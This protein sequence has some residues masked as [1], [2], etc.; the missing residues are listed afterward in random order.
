MAA[1]QGMRVSPANHS[2]ARL[3]RKCDY[4]TDTKTERQTPDKMIPMCRYASQT[5]QQN[6]TVQNSLHKICLK[7]DLQSPMNNLPV[8]HCNPHWR[9]P[10]D[11]STLPVQTWPSAG[12]P[13]GDSTGCVALRATLAG[14]TGAECPA[15]T[16]RRTGSYCPSSPIAV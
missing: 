9:S 16:M 1:F 15:Q 5:T 6:T 8:E 2:Y 14:Q 3:P 12:W 7:T 13:R 4:W 10:A 11:S